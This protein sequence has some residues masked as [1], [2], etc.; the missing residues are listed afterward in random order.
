LGFENTLIGDKMKKK[1]IVRGPALSRS[2]Y[3]E[4]AR[5]A[6][7]SLRKYPEHFDVVLLCTN[8]GRTGNL[9]DNS[10]E[11]QSINKLIV[12]SQQR[13]QAKEQF[14]ISIQISIP[15][16]FEKMAPVNIGYT[17]GIETTKVSPQ[18]IEKSM[19]MDKIIV[20][21]EHSKQVF[22][23]TVY[24]AIN[25]A[26]KQQFD[27]KNTKPIDVV[28]FPVKSLVPAVLDLDLP[29]DFNFLTVAQ[30]GPRKNLEATVTAF[31]EEFKNEEVGLVI[32]TNTVKNCVMDRTLTEMRLTN[33][34]NGLSKDRKCKIH[35]LHGNMTDEE[36][37][38][39]YV[40]PRIKAFVSTTHGEGFGI[41]LFEAASAG[42]PIAAPFWSGQMDFLKAPKKDKDSGKIRM[43]SHCVKIDFELKQVQKE[44]VWNG[45]IQEDSKWAFVKP[46]SVRIAMREMVKNLP[47]QVSTAKKLQEHVLKTFTEET[48]LKQFAESVLGRSFQSIL[49]NSV[50]KNPKSFDSISFCI[51]TNGKKTEITEMQ[52]RSILNNANKS[53]IKSEIVVCGIVDQFEKFKDD[54]VKLV[55]ATKLAETGMLAA[56]RNKAAEKCESD[57]LVFC[58]DDIIF[59][60][61]WLNRLTEFSTTKYWDV[62]GNKILLPDGGR[63]W[64][65]ATIKPHTMVD[66][67]HPEDDMNLYQTGCFWILRREVFNNE[68]WDS[69]IPY[70]AEKN[71]GIN[72]D[73]EYSRRLI[74]KGVNL[75]FDSENTVW[76]LDSRYKE[77]SLPNGHLICVRSDAESDF[78]IKDFS[79]LKV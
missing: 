13:I 26:T 54:R 57:V 67:E 49:N 65:R 16:E 33:L 19:L 25:Q 39:L 60:D 58:D 70:Y 1:I 31:V 66:Y 59:E 42:L 69:S 37:A 43:R 52:I 27:F 14:D 20:I 35:L 11:V 15:N 17:A 46:H 6:L 7:Q 55:D 79:Y 5:L 22:N 47:P 30:W 63:Y 51:S 41:P 78:S 75:S 9:L 40:H 34:L 29:C 36:M 64:D 38:A 72:E 53:N 73:L 74:S 12:D 44:A 2:G 56:L 76:H 18:W 50:K 10:E 71:G 21:S 61:D 68:K 8:W 48:V 28:G 23:D 3:G 4:M 32:K 24:Q 62:L 77:V 45:V